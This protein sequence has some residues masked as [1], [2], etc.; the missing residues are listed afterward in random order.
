[1]KR[2]RGRAND[3]V[4]MRNRVLD[5]AA[6]SFQSDGF[7][8]TSTHDIAKGAGVTGG[9]LHHHFP[10]KKALA[11][12]VIGE[13]VAT[14]LASTWITTVRDASSAEEGML[15]VFDSVIAILDAQGS[16]S[17]CPI[18]NL[19]LELSLADADLRAA[20]V[21]AYSNW[22]AAIADRIRLDHQA[23]RAR[24]AADPESFA[25]VVIALFSG[26]MTIAKA[27]QSSSAL[28]ACAEQ[29]RMMLRTSPGAAPSRANAADATAN[30]EP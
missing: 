1:M 7:R 6:R 8:A 17:G 30:T 19:T 21:G 3:P 5:V 15:Q 9:A 4:G 22:R 11:L 28:R 20:L 27:E 23:G 2:A 10:T 24:Y 26:A 25:N 18:A 29:L 14:E 12:A 16:V 13:R